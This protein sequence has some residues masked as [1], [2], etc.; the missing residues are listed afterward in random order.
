MIQSALTRLRRERRI[1][2]FNSAAY[3]AQIEEQQTKWGTIFRSLFFSLPL[4]DYVLQRYIE[5]F[6]FDLQRCSFY[7][8]TLKKKVEGVAGERFDMF[9]F[10]FFLKSSSGTSLLQALFISS[11]RWVIVFGCVTSGAGAPFG[12][13]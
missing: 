7:C 2:L 5:F 11:S 3:T 10:I 8:V 6:D 1:A 12:L 4:Y 9:G 13:A